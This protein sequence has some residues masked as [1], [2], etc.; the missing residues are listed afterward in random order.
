MQEGFVIDLGD[1]TQRVSKWT[2]GRPVKGFIGGFKVKDRRQFTTVTFRCPK[3][4]WLIW[5]APDAPGSEE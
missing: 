3:C 5:F 4:G 1:K 2:E